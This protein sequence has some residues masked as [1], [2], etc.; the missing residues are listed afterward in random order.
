MFKKLLSN[1]LIKDSFIYTIFNGIN[2]LI[3][4]ILLPVLTSYLTPNEYGLVALYKTNILLIYPFIGLCMGF[5]IDKNFFKVSKDYLAKQIGNILIIQVFLFLLFTILFFLISLFYDLSFIGFQTH[6]LFIIPLVC[7]LF[8]FNEYNLIIL[9][10]QSKS[11]SYGYW[12]ILHT[13]I[14]LSLSLFFIISLSYGWEGRA[15]GIVIAQVVMGFAS[16]KRMNNSGF[17]KVQFDKNEI[18]EIL[19]LCLPLV[20]HGLATYIIFQSN[21]YFIKMNVGLT[22]VGIF[23]VALAFSSIMGMIKDGLAKTIN[24]WIYKNLNINSDIYLFK[25]KLTKLFAVL[26]LALIVFNTII[27]VFSKLV[28]KYFLDE[29]YIEASNL[30]FILITATSL[31]VLYGI[32]CSFYVHFSK[33]NLLSKITVYTAL[34]SLGL[35]YVLTLKFGLIGSCYALLLAMMFQLIITFYF[36][37]KFFPFFITIKTIKHVKL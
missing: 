32:L 12:Q 30:V 13:I 35:N 20:L 2:G 9:R 37:T 8:S 5:Y 26:S 31:Y 29:K 23:S 3:P 21:F 33:T 34:I 22:A 17:I 15:L 19:S 18:I 7:F 24:P 36:C 4:F 6:W 1:S 25:Q 10:N 11:L 16:L 27:T 14:N 28:I